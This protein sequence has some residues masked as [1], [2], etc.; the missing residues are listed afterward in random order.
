M[1]EYL[2]IDKSINKIQPL[3]SVCLVTYNHVKYIRQCIDSILSQKT[4]FPFELIIGEDDSTD[5]TRD[6]CKNY[7]EKFPDKI[8]LFLREE[9]DKTWIDGS[10]TGRYNFIE[11]LKAAKGK[12]IAL[13]EGDDY[14]T[15]PL[16]LQMQVDFLESES[17][18]KLCFHRSYLL[19]GNKK[20][21]FNIPENQ[22][23]FRIIDLISKNNFI[24]TSSVIYRK[25]ENFQI[26]EWFCDLPFADIALYYLVVKDGYI[27]CLPEFMSAYRIHENGLWSS[28]NNWDNLN[29]LVKF[30]NGMMPYFS[31]DLKTATIKKRNLY[32]KQL[33]KLKYPD[34]KWKR[35]V[36]VLVNDRN[37]G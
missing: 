16:K 31:P 8:R 26:P 6:I 1:N 10:K 30:L 35:K 22:S 14:W 13:C 21:I 20:E 37:K 7:A 36:F 4:N 18:C 12:Y 32:V 33:A 23:Y 2:G 27:Y 24:A 17:K 5:G 25:P 9:K 34:N 19:K 28:T 3:V 15:E 11:N 29:K